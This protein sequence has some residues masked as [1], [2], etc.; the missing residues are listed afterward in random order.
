MSRISLH[1]ITNTI[2]SISNIGDAVGMLMMRRLGMLSDE[3]FDRSDFL[4][5]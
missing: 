1:N 5:S 3:L 2:A 4:E